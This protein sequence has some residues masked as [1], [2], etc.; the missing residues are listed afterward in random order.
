MSELKLKST[1][2]TA[3]LKFT[4]DFDR[5]VDPANGQIVAW[6]LFDGTGP[7]IKGS[8]NVSSIVDYGVGS[9]GMVFSDPMTDA[10]YAVVRGGDG[11]FTNAY[12]GSSGSEAPTV[13]EVRLGQ[14]NVAGTAQDVDND[15]AVVVR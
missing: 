1:T 8:F 5:D 13:S 3:T 10:N 11:A 6:V 15:A 7:T 14:R 12:K 9:Y 2:N 4:G